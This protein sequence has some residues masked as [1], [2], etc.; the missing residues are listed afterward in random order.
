[1]RERMVVQLKF[2]ESGAT[3]QSSKTKK[4]SKLT[5]NTTNYNLQQQNYMII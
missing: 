5:S 3:R 1:M 4:Y 2:Q